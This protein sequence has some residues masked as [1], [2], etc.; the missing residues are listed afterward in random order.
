MNQSEQLNA[1]ESA[2]AVASGVERATVMGVGELI[3]AVTLTLADG[4]RLRIAG[5]GYLQVSEIAHAECA[6]SEDNR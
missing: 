6:A 3:V 1:F 4:R 5:E 2:R